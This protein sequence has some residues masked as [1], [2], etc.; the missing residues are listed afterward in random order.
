MV[1]MAY[2]LSEK[3]PLD[4]SISCYTFHRL[5]KLTRGGIDSLARRRLTMKGACVGDNAHNP[6]P[7]ILE[8]HDYIM[9]EKASELCTTR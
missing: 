7:C 3:S 8:M 2:L 6:A 4:S 5:R 9:I 1:K